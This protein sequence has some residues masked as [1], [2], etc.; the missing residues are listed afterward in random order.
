M[1][2]LDLNILTK[3]L[4][5]SIN[6][7]EWWLLKYK[8]KFEQIKKIEN[9]KNLHIAEDGT[10]LRLPM[11]FEPN[12]NDKFL[13]LYKALD[14]L[15]EFHKF[16]EYFSKQMIEY[17]KVKSSQA[18]LKEWL[19]KNEKLG[20][21]KFVCF[22]IDYLDYDEDDKVEHLNIFVHSATEIK[23]FVDREGFKNTIFFLETF[24]EIYW[25]DDSNA[26]KN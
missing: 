22:L 10:I 12:P 17:S 19:S 11:S 25:T 4:P 3:S 13:A 26:K 1:E 9:S 15:T 21:D 24:N 5:I 6:K 18:E 23:I 16:E 8:G 20:A 14:E 2:N 7:V